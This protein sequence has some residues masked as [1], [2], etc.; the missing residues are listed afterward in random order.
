MKQALEKVLYLL[1]GSHISCKNGNEENM[2]KVFILCFDA[3]V[4]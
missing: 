1:F 4:A 3:L 2:K